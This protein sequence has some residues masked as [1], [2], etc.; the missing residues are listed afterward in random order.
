MFFASISFIQEMYLQDIF[1]H[2]CYY[3]CSPGRFLIKCLHPRNIFTTMYSLHYTFT[4]M[5]SPIEMSVLVF[6]FSKDMF[7]PLSLLLRD[8]WLYI[9]LCIPSTI[10]HA[11]TLRML[12]VLSFVSW[13]CQQIQ[14]DGIHVIFVNPALSNLASTTLW[15]A[16]FII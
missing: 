5:S 14:T 7:K 2:V 11:L 15:G 13:F 16:G 10:K 4:S 3:V 1:R 9:F 12:V 6:L 8:V